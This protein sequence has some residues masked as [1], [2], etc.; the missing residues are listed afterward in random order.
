MTAEFPPLSIDNLHR[1]YTNGNFTPADVAEH[2][3]EG[4]RSDE[5]NA[6][7]SLV[8]EQ[9]VREAAKQRTRELQSG[10]ELPTEP[11]FGIPF[12]IKDNI[13]CEGRPTTAACPS[14][15]H[16]AEESATAL[17]RITEAGGILIGKTN[18]DQFATGVVG[19]RSP[20]GPCR[21]AIDKKY[22]SGGSSS[23][24]AVAVADNQVTFTLGTDTG[25]SG[26]VPAACNGIFGL[27]PSRGVIPKSGVVP[28]CKSLDCVSVF[29]ASPLDALLVETVA[30][31]FDFSDVYSDREADRISLSPQAVDPSAVIGIPEVTQLDFFSD[32]ESIQLFNEWIDTVKESKFNTEKYDLSPF[33]EC[34]S[35]LFDGPW[36]A[37]RNIAIKNRVDEYSE[38]LLGVIQQVLASADDFTAE[39]V[40]L[41]EHEKK[42][43]DQA[44]TAVFESVDYICVP[45]IGTIYT[46]E[47][48][49]Q[50]PLETNSTL[51]LY[52]NFVNLFDLCAVTIPAGRRETGLPF[53]VTLIGQKY[54][55]HHLATVADEICSI[56]EEKIGTQLSYT[57]L[58]SPWQ[59]LDTPS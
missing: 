24:S 38:D 12:G 19:T 59:L 49:E 54:D 52:T 6:W 36:V 43:L 25:G 37:E 41:A 33:T 34:S 9:D 29:A 11:L 40:F 3:L 10:V 4:V 35:L 7:I 1:G 20:Y 50:R 15:E 46:I 39:D 48:V 5:H 30:A 57:D 28:A 17:K 16:I 45:T 51:G 56:T 53:S 27:K 18:L 2:V 31:G 21:N 26:R 42:R 22:I 58:E 8:D 32:Q 13:D 55:E 47:E 14:F 44:A 23:G